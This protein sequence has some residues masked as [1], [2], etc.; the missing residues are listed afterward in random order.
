LIFGSQGG[1][2]EGAGGLEG[3]GYDVD[4]G[5]ASD[6]VPERE[7]RGRGGREGVMTRLLSRGALID[8]TRG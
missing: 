6:F 2:G 7:G 5:W 4:E 1:E 8:S 3:A